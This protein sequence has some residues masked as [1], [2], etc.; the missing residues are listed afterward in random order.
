MAV[1]YTD[2]TKVR[3]FIAG[4]VKAT[5]TDA[6]INV[7]IE[8]AEGMIDTLM[9]IGSGTGSNSLTFSASAKPHL[10]LELATTA[11]AASVAAANSTESMATMQEA[12]LKIE[13]CLRWYKE[14][15]MIM[16]QHDKGDFIME[17]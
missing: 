7:W 13:H 16:Q 15:I 6:M 10:V 11:M 5:I 9:K 3:N 14:A 12:V 2:A 1:K 8:E 4:K 17:Q